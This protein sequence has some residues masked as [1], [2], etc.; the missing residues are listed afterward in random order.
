MDIENLIHMAN[1]IGDFFQAL[2]DRDEALAG[3]ADH[4]RKFWDP[5]MRRQLY[6]ALDAGEG[7]Q[8]HE[9]VRAAVDA[10]RA[11][12]MPAAPAAS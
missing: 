1:R 6:A 9:I 4:I 5:R 10:H 8:L 2:P 3:I 7:A 11:K 12:L